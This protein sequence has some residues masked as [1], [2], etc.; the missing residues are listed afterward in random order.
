MAFLLDALHED[1]GVAMYDQRRGDSWDPKRCRKWCF[2][3]VTNDVCSII[4]KFP[5]LFIWGLQK[6]DLLILS[7]QVWDE[8]PNLPI[9]LL[10]QGELGANST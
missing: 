6:R 9:P 1:D 5:T 3:D 8:H 4:S 10:N 2:Q 7:D